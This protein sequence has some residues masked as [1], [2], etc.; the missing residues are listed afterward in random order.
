MRARRLCLAL[1]VAV[2]L[3]AQRVL[4]QVDP[5]QAWLGQPIRYLVQAQDANEAQC[6]LDPVDGL[7]FELEGEGV[8]DRSTRIAV[9]NGRREMRESANYTFAY[10]VS[11]SRA[12][13]FVI[14]PPRVT[15]GASTLRGETRVLVIEDPARDDRVAIEFRAEPP[16]LVLG[17]D[18]T[19]VVDVFLATPDPQLQTREPLDLYDQ[20]RSFSLF[21][22]GTPPPS[23]ALPWL[24]NP[25][26]GLGPID[27]QAWVNARQSRRGFSIPEVRGARFL[28][29]QPA[30]VSRKRRDGSDGS[31]R[32]YRFTLPIRGELAGVHELPAVT[33]QGPLVGKD[34]ARLAWRDAFASSA[35]LALEVREP[36]LDGRPAEFSGAVGHFAFEGKQPTPDH[37]RVGD[38][39]YLTF[40][41]SGRG[42]LKGVDL[43]LQARLGDRFRV[44]RVG[45]TDSLAPGAERPPGFPDR[46]GLWRQWD[47]KVYPQATECSAIP[48]VRFA[49]Y[50]PDARA[51]ATASTTA[52]PIT[53]EAASSAEVVVGDGGA[54]RRDVALVATA[55]LA[56]NV[57]DLARLEDQTPRPWPWLVVLASLAPLYAACSLVVTRRRRLHEDPALLRKRRA[58]SRLLTRLRAARAASGA[59]AV[60]DA[61]AALCG[62]VADVEDQNEVALTA[63]ELADWVR[64]AGHGD[65]LCRRVERLGA[66]VEAARYGAGASEIDASTLDGL[67]RIAERPS[68]KVA[69]AVLAFAIAFAGL[70]TVPRAQDVAGFA[71]AQAAFDA[72]DFDGA[73]RGFRD[74]LAA[75]YENGWVLYDLGNAELRAGR[76]GASIAA[77]RRASLFLCGDPNLDLNLQRALEAR[78]VPL[79]APASRSVLDHVLFWSE[80]LPMRTELAIAVVTGLLAFGSA[81][82]RLA[83]VGLER[84]RRLAPL[85][86]L[87]LVLAGAS[88]LFAI[89]AVRDWRH[90]VARDRGVVVI[91]GTTLRTGPGES[92]EAR[93]TEPLGEG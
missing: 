76:V 86:G 91:E 80:G 82:I 1:L 63:A 84:G 14:P 71:T 29:G 10:K 93:Y 68:R 38:A 6:A 3:P 69:S 74:L 19:L 12:G 28:E 21:D 89:S 67:E 36:P 88:V 66:L 42:F 30:D 57:T 54:A 56:A 17:Q 41:V 37:V 32:R 24:A 13:R 72:G 11:A 60:R 20:A 25:P 9:I 73:A 49:W 31:Y 78:R 92:F 61:H 58:R 52:M 48:P 46:A 4:T 64:A 23:L 55:A 62:Y 34:G 15:I 2:P 65:E 83:L 5:A 59:A 90:V 27:R 85:R 33:L 35:P 22:Q 45:I 53:V 50:D 81:L 77:Y 16:S 75:D 87:A 7:S 70:T 44:E 8:T 39:I 26:Q 79:S 40:V 18:G 51:Y 47:F 43:D